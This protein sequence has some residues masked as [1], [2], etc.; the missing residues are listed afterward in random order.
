MSVRD[1]W[2]EVP[3]LFLQVRED[4][5]IPTTR[6]FETPEEG[7]ASCSGSRSLLTLTPPDQR[8]CPRTQGQGHQRDTNASF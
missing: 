6:A 3:T 1:F 4:F 7:A 8:L 2:K 5:L